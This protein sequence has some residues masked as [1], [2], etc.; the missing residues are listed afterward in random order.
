MDNCCLAFPFYTA[1]GD[2]A[3]RASTRYPTP[4]SAR[5]FNRQ[6]VT[7]VLFLRHAPVFRRPPCK[8]STPPSAFPRS[9]RSRSRLL[10][11]ACPRVR[12]LCASLSFPPLP[13]SPSHGFPSSRLLSLHAASRLNR[14]KGS[15]RYKNDR[16]LASAIFLLPSPPLPFPIPLGSVFSLAPPTSYACFSALGVF[17]PLIICG[18]ETPKESRRSLVGRSRS[19]RSPVL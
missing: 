15:H 16:H 13:L 14:T 6:S 10:S 17:P 2:F 7:S 9:S 3:L 12:L 18:N 19:Y 4:V 8:N 5:S 1:T 11:F